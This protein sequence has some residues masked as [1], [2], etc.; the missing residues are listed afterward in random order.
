MRDLWRDVLTERYGYQCIQDKPTRPRSK[1]YKRRRNLGV[2][3]KRKWMRY[4]RES[5]PEGYEIHHCDGN[6][7]NNHISNL[8]L[9]TTQHHD[10]IHHEGR[11]KRIIIKEKECS[12]F[13]RDFQHN[14]LP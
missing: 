9:V 5:I 12:F 1:A 10:A 13:I 11:K 8:A 3:A 6:I 14:L 2:R 4:W 7:R